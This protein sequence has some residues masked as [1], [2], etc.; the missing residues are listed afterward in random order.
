MQSEKAIKGMPKRIKIPP[1]AALN[2]RR[3]ISDCDHQYGYTD[4]TVRRI[5]LQSHSHLCKRSAN[6]RPIASIVNSGFAEESFGST[7]STSVK[8]RSTSQ[9]RDTMMS[10]KNRE[11][12]QAR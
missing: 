11:M 2:L 5:V 3:R 4:R 7:L 10:G 1:P 9:H 8:R 12:G 6:D